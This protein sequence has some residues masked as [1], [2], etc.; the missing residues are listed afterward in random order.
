MNKRIIKILVACISVIF[1]VAIIVHSGAL[2]P[3]IYDG[4]IRL[5]ITHS[6]VKEMDLSELSKIVIRHNGEE[7]EIASEESDFDTIRKI[8]DNKKVKIDV[9]KIHFWSKGKY[10]IEFITGEKNYI[11][12]GAPEVVVDTE[13]SKLQNPVCFVMYDYSNSETNEQIY[14]IVKISKK[15]FAKIF[16]TIID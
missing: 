3:L 10:E 14:Q 9:S 8:F 1:I 5:S 11:L 12:Y 13:T 6:D 2:T 16:G 7:Y 15:D 4:I